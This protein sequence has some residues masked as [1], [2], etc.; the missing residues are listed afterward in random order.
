MSARQLIV[1]GVA[2][3]VAIGALFVVRGIGAQRAAAPEPSAQVATVNV[4]VAARDIQQGAALV[5][6]D[7]VWR[8][9]P[10]ESV[11]ERFVQ[12]D[13]APEAMTEL[14]D[15]IARRA[16]AAGE[17]IIQGYVI[18]RNGGGFMA[19]VLPV[20]YRAVSVRMDEDA[21]AGG[22]IQPNDRVDV[23]LTRTLQVQGEDSRDEKRSDIVLE[24][25][26]VLAVGDQVR[27]Q[28]GGDAPQRIMQDTVLLELSAEDARILALAESMGELSLALRSVEAEAEGLQVASARR[29][30]V[31]DQNI[32]Q[33]S[34]K[35]HAFSPSGGG[36]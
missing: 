21:L 13:A 14:T 9:F 18:P 22:Y 36:N 30:G 11:G 19:A 24:N 7:T 15:A 25:V 17:P 5:A 35:L 10:R 12:Q 23:L 31:L 33:D 20:G 16:F 8:P 29:R 6:G 26:R 3:L 4:L 1:L 2:L 27:P 32:R 34:V 28:E